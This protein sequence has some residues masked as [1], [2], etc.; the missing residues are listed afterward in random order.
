MP[1]SAPGRGTLCRQ[2][3]VRVLA[4]S[5]EV[6]DALLADAGVAR[7]VA[8]ILA[9]GDLPL[10]YL[11]SLMNRLDVPL[12]FVPGNHDPDLGGYRSSR[13][14]LTPRVR[15]PARPPWPE[16]A[17]N[18]DGRVVDVGGLWVAGLGVWLRYN[19][20]PNQYPARKQARRAW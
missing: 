5:D 11:G 14:G 16:R 19:E 2:E 10:E 4:V 3:P 15:L 8:L 1:V 13:A 18:A 12:A 7:R 9:C 20:P 17:V 6:D